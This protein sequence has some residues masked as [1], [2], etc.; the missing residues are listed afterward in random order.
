MKIIPLLFS[1]LSYGT[2]EY[3]FLVRK[4]GQDG[5]DEDARY[6]RH[7]KVQGIEARVW[8]GKVKVVV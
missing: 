8:D 1:D 3:G 2:Q 5:D 4:P 7:L 6:Q